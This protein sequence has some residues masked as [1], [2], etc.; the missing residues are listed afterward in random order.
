RD[1]ELTVGAERDARAVAAG[2]RTLSAAAVVLRG[3][4]RAVPILRDEDVLDVRELRAAV[5]AGAR[6][7]ER[8]LLVV[9]GIRLRVRE[10]DEAVA[11][12]VRVEREAHQ[13][14]DA[15]ADDFRQPFDRRR[16]ELA[17]AD[18]AEPPRPL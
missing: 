12:E 7:G 13:A 17:V 6:D 14:A 15:L 10:I 3:H 18:H 4:R 1:V 2:S 16:V 8:A 11:F 9:L 5:P